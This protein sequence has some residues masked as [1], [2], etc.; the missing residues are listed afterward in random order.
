ME[1]WGYSSETRNR[2]RSGDHFHYLDSEGSGGNRNIDVS[3]SDEDPVMDNNT[4]SNSGTSSNIDTSDLK[5]SGRDGD[6]QP[7]ENMLLLS[8]N[9]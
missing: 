4:L 3:S 9:N 5:Y 6:S 8:E 2:G 1:I 7:D